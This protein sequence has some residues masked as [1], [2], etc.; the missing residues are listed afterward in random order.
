MSRLNYTFQAFQKDHF[1]LPVAVMGL[2]MLI[3]L[4][5]TGDRQYSVVRA[6]LGFTLP[7]LA[8]GL[9]AY[10]FLE[11]SA[12]ELQFA[13]KRPAWKMIA[14]RLGL[15]LFVIV[16]VS[17]TFQLFIQLLGVSLSPL[18]NV[19]QR[20]LVWFV[21]CLTTLVLGGAVS[22][23]AR[24]SNGG[25]AAVG[26]LWIIQI[27]LRGW[28]A[29]EPVWRNVLL[30]YGVMDPLG[31]PRILNQITLTVFS[32]LLLVAAHTLLKKQERYI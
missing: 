8:G 9:S 17:L 26:G 30:F 15:V 6:F 23:M 3:T 14:E 7:L 10:T 25:M 27:L 29:R 5:M 28:F 20:Q 11:D 12:L 4:L 1:W 32:L 18:G 13:T 21:P 2:F 24:N 22:L 19:F 31:Q 16:F